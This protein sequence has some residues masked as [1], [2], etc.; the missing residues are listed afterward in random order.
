MQ[1]VADRRQACSGTYLYAVT[2]KQLQC[3]GQ[4][5]DWRLQTTMQP[6]IACG[7]PPARGAHDE[8][9]LDQVGFEHVL[10]GAAFLA[11]RRGQVVQP[12]RAA[13]ELLDHGLQQAAVF[14][15]LSRVLREISEPGRRAA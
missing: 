8:A 15:E 6:G 12:D 4:R 2:V 3:I 11:D 14:A 13:V 7:D 10:D 5:L 9:L 1:R